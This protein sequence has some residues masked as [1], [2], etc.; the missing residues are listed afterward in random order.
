M[1][2]IRLVG[3]SWYTSHHR[4]GLYTD[5]HLNGA[6]LFPCREDAVTAAMLLAVAFPTWLAGLRVVKVKKLRI[7]KLMV[8]RDAKGKTT[9]LWPEE[10]DHY[11]TA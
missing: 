11:V 5:P 3:N 10:V 9:R 2:A 8:E 7:Q 1:Y 6:K 4:L